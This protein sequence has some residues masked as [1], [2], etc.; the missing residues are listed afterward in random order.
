M[1]LISLIGKYWISILLSGIIIILC[2]MS[3]EPMPSVPM[4]NFDKLV[5][6]LM[7]LGLSGVV[8][9]DNTKYF[10]KQISYQ[11]IIWGSFFFPTIFSGL[12]EL[13]QEYLS[14]YRTGDWMDFLWD[15]VGAFVGLAICLKINSKLQAG[16]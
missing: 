14:S 5:H 7:F 11:R 1:K 6:F 16:K 13:M 3:T 8:F 12:I 9:F 2:F 4:S 10:R 15:T